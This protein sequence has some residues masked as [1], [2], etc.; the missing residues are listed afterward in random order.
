VTA[1]PSATPIIT[2]RGESFDSLDP[3]AVRHAHPPFSFG[4]ATF[5]PSSA[6][7]GVPPTSK[8]A[9][10]LSAA[11]SSVASP[12]ASPPSA[13][14]SVPPSV[15]PSAPASHGEVAHEGE[16][17][18]HVP[19]QPVVGSAGQVRVPCGAPLMVEHV[20]M[21]PATSHASHDPLHGLSQQTKSTQLPDVHS[22][23]VPHD[24]PTMDLGTHLP[25][26]HQ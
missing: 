9:G 10:P 11:D 26:W 1:T 7:S 21:R 13:A 8:G 6:V 18:S 17:P 3:I 24:A 2:P 20:P 23:A 5:A 19:G 14:P 4:C 15:P 16:V 12:P 25:V 22:A